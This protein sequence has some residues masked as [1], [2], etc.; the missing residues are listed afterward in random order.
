[1]AWPAV[2]REFTQES[3]RRYVAGLSWPSWRPS[4]IVWHNTAAQGGSEHGMGRVEKHRTSRAI[5]LTGNAPVRRRER[6]ARWPSPQ[7]E[8]SSFRENLSFLPTPPY[9]G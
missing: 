6:Y 3:F 4:K 2:K 8:M 7:G 9:S 1:M 5:Y